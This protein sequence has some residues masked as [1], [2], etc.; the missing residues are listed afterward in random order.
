MRITLVGPASPWRGGIAHFNDLLARELDRGHEVEVLTFTRQYP[1]RLFPGRDQKHPSEAALDVGAVPVLDS[2][3][4]LSWWRT[5]RRIRRRDPDLLVFRYWMPFF[6]PAF[7]SVL[8]WAR[9]GG[10]PEVVVVADNVVPHE[11][12][13]LDG[14]LSRWFLGAADRFV[15]MSDA[16]RRDLE[17]LLPGARVATVPHPLYGQFGDPIPRQEARRDL[18][19]GLDEPVL[20]YF[21]FVRR[22]KGLDILLDALPLIRRRLPARLLVVGE[23]YEERSRYERQ[24]RRLGLTEAVRIHDEYVPN[25]A[26]ARWFSAADLVVLPYRHATQSGIIPV[27]YHMGRTV[28]STRVGGLAEVVEDGRSGLLVPP[29][30]PQAL[31]RAVVRFYEED[32][33]APLEEGVRAIRRRFSWTH[34]AD[35]VTGTA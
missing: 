4:P 18:G 29:E 27:A 34:F 33:A 22:Y 28:V 21:G 11:R 24:I 6:A 20:L 25:H 1:S 13:P 12:R 23:F 31:A 7:G 10:R 3:D 16:V 15:V 8:R 14:L 30:D 17:A 35:A 2:I 32:L 9:R 26:V 19:L 5:G